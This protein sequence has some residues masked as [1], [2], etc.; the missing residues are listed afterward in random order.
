MVDYE[1]L[2]HDSVAIPLMELKR[3]RDELRRCRHYHPS[4]NR[5]AEQVAGLYQRVWKTLQQKQET[6]R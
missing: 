2:E 1:K 5:L 3:I 6:L 4:V